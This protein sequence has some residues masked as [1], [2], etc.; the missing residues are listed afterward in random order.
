MLNGVNDAGKQE[1]RAEH[2]AA[3]RQCPVITLSYSLSQGPSVLEESASG[4][5][6]CSTPHVAQDGEHKVDLNPGESEAG[7]P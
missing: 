5:L 3:S 7:E 1:A 6:W 4:P 2:R